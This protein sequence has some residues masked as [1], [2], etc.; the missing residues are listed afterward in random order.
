MFA[1]N[2]SLNANNEPEGSGKGQSNQG[3]PETASNANKESLPADMGKVQYTHSAYD[4]ILDFTSEESSGG[5]SY[6]EEFDVDAIIADQEFYSV[7][8]P[9]NNNNKGEKRNLEESDQDAVKRSK[10]M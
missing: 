8:S 6:V 9:L 3:S 1:F 2:F 4:T 7:G 5:E 10:K